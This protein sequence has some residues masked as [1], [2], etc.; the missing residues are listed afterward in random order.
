VVLLQEVWVPALP[1]GGTFEADLNAPLDV[2]E[3]DEGQYVVA[4]VN[5]EMRFA[6]ANY[7]NNDVQ[8]QIR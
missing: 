7:D 8:L 6:E 5:S 3:D 4:E 1:P 2:G